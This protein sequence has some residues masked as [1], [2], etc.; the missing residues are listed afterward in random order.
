VEN[1]HCF[2]AGFVSLTAAVLPA[3]QLVHPQSYQV[4]YDGMTVVYDGVVAFNG[5]DYAVFF[6]AQDSKEDHINPYFRR[7]SSDGIPAGPLRRL[8]NNPGTDWA[9][10]AIWDGSA[11]IAAYANYDNEYVYFMRISKDGKVLLKKNL[12]GNYRTWPPIAERSSTYGQPFMAILGDEVFLCFTIGID[13]GERS[14]IFVKGPK[15]LNGEFDVSTLPVGSFSNATLCGMTFDTEGFLALVG[16]MDPDHHDIERVQCVAIGYDGKAAAAPIQLEEAIGTVDFITGPVFFGEGFLIT[17]TRWQGTY[18]THNSL[19]IDRDGKTVNG[20][21]KLGE[22]ASILLWRSLIWNGSYLV[23]IGCDLQLYPVT[24]YF[25]NYNGKFFANPFKGGVESAGSTPALV[26]NGTRTTVVYTDELPATHF[27]F[28]F[29]N[30]F[31]IPSNI[32]KPAIEFFDYGA[33]Y[34]GTKRVVVWSAIGCTNVR[35]VGKG[36]KLKNQAPVGLALV[37]TKGKKLQLKLKIKGPGGR[38]SR[39]LVIVP[40]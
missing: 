10:A 22:A 16:E 39:K 7:I 26:F 9:M 17:Y 29:T 27:P 31:S 1:E 34:L 14:V 18:S 21:N 38:A 35:L 25:F 4:S 37:D 12:S 36:V 24:L 19:V 13:F 6:S 2:F 32:T 28:M 40:E 15:S 11:Y 5:I 20:P 33:D 3:Q 8:L 30:Q 23:S